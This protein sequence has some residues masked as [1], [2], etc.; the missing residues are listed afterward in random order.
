MAAD[1]PS[2]CADLSAEHEDLDRIVASLDAVGWD[3]P[4]PAEGW[5]VRDQIAH[6]AFFD[7][8]ATTAAADPEAFNSDLAEIAADPAGFLEGH[9]RPGRAMDPQTLVDCWRSQRTTMLGAFLGLDPATR[10]PWFGPPMGAASFITARLMETWCH[11]QD[12]ADALRIERRPTP[13]LRHVAHIAVKAR[14]F[15][16][17]SHGLAL[18]SS[19]VLVE[20][21]GPDGDTWSWGDASVSDRVSGEAVDFCLVATQRRHRADT[22]LVVEGPLAEEWMAIAQAFAGPPGPGR[23]PGQFPRHAAT[24]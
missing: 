4:T 19:D 8:S 21:R 9:L 20:L 3:T 7:S 2:L 24:A 12:V 10:I 18:P 13:R 5:A 11:G 23:R 1:I 6:L 14:P 22:E 17:A 15:N 16:Y